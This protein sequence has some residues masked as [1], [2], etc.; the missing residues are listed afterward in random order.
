MTQVFEAVSFLQGSYSGAFLLF[1]WVMLVTCAVTWGIQSKNNSS[2]NTNAECFLF[3]VFGLA[4][5]GFAALRPIGIARDDLGYLQIYNT[6][7]P[8]FD[9]GQLI[10]GERDWGWYS[11]IALLKSVVSDPK[12][13]LWSAAVA[14]LIKLGVIYSLAARPLPVLL[15]YLAFFYEIH[16]L[17]ALRVSFAIAI[18]MGAIWLLAHCRTYWNWWALFACGFFH[19]QAFVAPLILVGSLFRTY[20]WLSIAVCLIPVFLLNIGIYPKLHLIL[21]HMSPEF[22]RIIVV[23]GL[24]TQIRSVVAGFY[25]G[26]RVAPVVAY[27]QI[28]L[29]LWLLI[30]HQSSNDRLTSLLTGC[31]SMGCLFL[32]GFASLPDAQVR[33]FDFFMVPTVLLAGMRRLKSLEL[34]GVFAVSGVFVIK[35]NILH[36]LLV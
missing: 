6:L 4:M 34:A 23:Q 29:I 5:V 21:P 2:I 24:D 36:H 10:Q 1:W 11:L 26:W 16:D 28:L 7:C 9:C 25:N 13:V 27:P 12:V 18:F 8:T 22:Q 30:K 20:R 3:W 31:L 15:L 17:I 19:K 33:L 32:W 14:L 35:Y